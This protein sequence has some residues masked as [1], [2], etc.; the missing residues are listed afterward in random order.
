[1]LAAQPLGQ[2]ALVPKGRLRPKPT[3]PAPVPR[4]V[5][6]RLLTVQPRSM[7]KRDALRGLNTT[8]R[9]CTP[10]SARRGSR[11]H[12]RGPPATAQL[13]GAGGQGGIPQPYPYR[14]VSGAAAARTS[15]AYLPLRE[16]MALLGKGKVP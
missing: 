11:P 4:L 2:H 14:T 13:R 3:D 6:Q 15:E 16:C 9:A 5:H 12:T 7:A 1:M 10:H 8:P